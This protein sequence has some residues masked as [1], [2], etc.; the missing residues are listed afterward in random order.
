MILLFVCFSCL[1]LLLFFRFLSPRL[2]SP[3]VYS[4]FYIKCSLFEF[5]DTIYNFFFLTFCCRSKRSKVHVTQNQLQWDTSRF[6]LVHFSFIVLLSVPFAIFLIRN[7]MFFVSATWYKELEM[8]QELEE[9]MSELSSPIRRNF[10]IPAGKYGKYPPHP[11]PLHP[12]PGLVYRDY[13]F[14]SLAC[15]P[16][17][18]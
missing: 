11:R 4:M 3:R 16:Y 18:I 8:N 6:C 2:L 15:Q 14:E 12:P 1:L 5:S 17:F 9:K 7:K 13:L 10:T